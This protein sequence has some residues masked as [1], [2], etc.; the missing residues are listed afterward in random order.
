VAASTTSMMIGLT[1]GGV[2]FPWSSPRILVT[3]IVGCLGLVLFVWYEFTIAKRP[4]VSFLPVSHRAIQLI[5]ESGSPWPF[6][7]P[8]FLQWVHTDLRIVH[9]ADMPL[10]WVSAR[11]PLIGKG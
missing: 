11:L 1:W 9:R 5:I 6:G 8:N 10:M 7:D 3:L 2:Q 4:I